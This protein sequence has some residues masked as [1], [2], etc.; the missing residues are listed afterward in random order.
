MPFFSQLLITV[1]L[2]VFAVATSCKKREYTSG[3]AVY[4]GKCLKCHK[5]NEKGGTKGPDLTDIF[6]RKDDEY[7]Q[8]YTQDPR[9]VK[10]DGTMPPSKLSDQ[11]LDLVIQYM[12]EK[13]RPVNQ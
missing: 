7:I 1:C 6:Q 2:F 11:E 4:E 10:P 13:G 9:S 12:K 3:E 5:L 8:N